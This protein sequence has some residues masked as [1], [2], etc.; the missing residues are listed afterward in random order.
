MQEP[1]KCAPETPAKEPEFTPYIKAEQTIA[2]FS[3]TAFILGML[4]AIIFGAANAYLGFKVGMTVSASIPAAVISMAILRGI[5][6]KGTVL[7]NNIVQ[8]IASTGES[9]A[10][11]VLFTIPGFLVLRQLLRNDATGL[12]EA[13]LPTMPDLLITFIIALLGGCLGVLMMIPLRRYLI[14]KE[15]GKLPYPEGTACAEV[16]IAGESGGV[17]AK[18]VFFGITLGAIYKF[19]MSGLALWKEE[20]FLLIP[21]F[22]RAAVAFDPSAAL[23]GVGFIIGPRIA[24]FMLAGGVIGWLVIIPLIGTFANAVGPGFILPPGTKPL[25]LMTAGEMASSYLRYIGAGAVAIGGLVS[26]LK[27]LPVIIDSFKHS[28]IG[29]KSRVTESGPVQ[30]K[31]TDRD[32]SMTFILIGCLVIIAVMGAVKQIPIGVVG[33]AFAVVFTFFFVSVSSR[34]VGII[35]SSSNPVS[36]MTITTLLIVSLVFAATGGTNVANM[37]AV[38]TIGAIVCIAICCAGDISQDLKTGFLLGSTPK[39]Q[40]I[41]QLLSVIIPT[42]AIVVVV[43][44]LVEA[45]GL[46]TLPTYDTKVVSFTNDKLVKQAY[47]GTI[48]FSD[49]SKVK[50]VKELPGDD[51]N[52]PML[53]FNKNNTIIRTSLD[54]ATLKNGTVITGKLLEKSLNEIVMFTA[55]NK[56]VHIKSEEIASVTKA[57]PLAKPEICP[58]NTNFDCTEKWYLYVESPIRGFSKYLRKTD[59]TTEIIKTAPDALYMKDGSVKEGKIFMSAKEWDETAKTTLKTYTFK[60]MDNKIENIAGN[61][62]LKIESGTEK[63][64]EFQ[65][66]QANIMAMLTKGVI[67]GE[68]PWVW[69]LAGAFLALAVELLGISSLPFAIGLYLGIKTGLPI[70]LGGMAFWIIKKLTTANKWNDTEQKS[71]L[72]ASGVIAGDALI[73]IVVAFVTIIWGSNILAMRDTKN[74]SSLLDEWLPY[75]LFIAITVISMLYI[76][77]KERNSNNG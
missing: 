22:N 34:I 76:G 39:K 55:E 62:V 69:V 56:A 64:G 42:I 23:L 51:K 24:A 50:F 27:G 6:R 30:T 9:M 7:E 45:H 28:I 37:I 33:A 46:E 61:D 13:G 40:Q 73:G 1:V 26:L 68:L 19:L 52:P 77:R 4:L 49:A 10:A 54:T 29:M 35:G 32:I 12:N 48:D 15:H 11:G 47:E 71:T 5:M 59:S 41:A 72:F 16:L 65:A 25:A 74:A 21:R 3:I 43:Y 8:T 60:N 66:P 44:L 36:G 31:R 57:K 58:E 38:L 2:E 70:M 67:K 63:L 75:M 18:H 14:V 17:K 53:E 20:G